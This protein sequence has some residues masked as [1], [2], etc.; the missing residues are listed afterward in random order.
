VAPDLPVLEVAPLA[1]LVDRNCIRSAPADPLVM[2][3][4]SAALAGA[5]LL[6]CFLPARRATRVTP[7][8]AL[9]GE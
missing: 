9:R 1:D 2:A 8:V 5:A 6:A 3:L 4:A 7:L